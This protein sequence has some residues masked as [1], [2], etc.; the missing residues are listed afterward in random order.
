MDNDAADVFSGL[1][2][3]ELTLAQLYL[4]PE[5]YDYV[6]GVMDGLVSLPPS[7]IMS[8]EFSI[9]YA[10]SIEDNQD[11]SCVL[12]RL[13]TNFKYRIGQDKFDEVLVALAKATH[14]SGDHDYSSAP[15]SWKL[16][17]PHTVIGESVR[18]RAST[19]ARPS[20][21]D[22]LMRFL[23]NSY[24]PT[25]EE[26]YVKW[27]KNNQHVVVLFMIQLTHTPTGE[28]RKGPK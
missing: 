12:C 10:R 18:F 9:A 26:V 27:L 24:P 3:R 11:L 15:E 22:A 7:A 28:I 1:L 8:N 21:F 19:L 20:L 14:I 4:K 2:S 6:K 25:S 16:E 13:L 5:D 17:D 23:G